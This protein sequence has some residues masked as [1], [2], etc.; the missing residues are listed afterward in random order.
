MDAKGFPWN[1]RYQKKKNPLFYRSVQMSL[2]YL[3]N[4]II[5]ILLKSGEEKG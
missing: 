3:L 5:I 4:I 1:H 2:S